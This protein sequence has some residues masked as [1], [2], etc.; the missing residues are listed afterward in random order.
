[1]VSHRARRSGA[2]T[3][4]AGLLLATR[5]VGRGR[6]SG[7]L[8]LMTHDSFYL[9]EAVI[10]SFEAAHG[11]DLRLLPAGDAGAMVNQAILTA[12]RPLADVLFGVD[13]TFLSRA[14]EADIFEPYASS[15]A[16]GRARASCSW[17]PSTGSRPST[18][19]DVCLNLDRAAFAEGGLPRPDDAS[20]TWPTRPWRACWWS[21]TRPPPRRAWPSCWP[22]WPHFGE[23]PRPAGRPT[24]PTCA[25]TT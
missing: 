9:P 25:T 23:D 22:P 17:T 6:R 18:S 12:D 1:M 8:T 14:L 2:V 20:R 24:G 7:T 10:E 19:V 16:G 5:P 11:V 15:R 13:N 4:A 3:L 21:R